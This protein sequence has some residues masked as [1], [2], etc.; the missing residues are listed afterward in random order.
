MLRYCKCIIPS[1]ILILGSNSNSKT[2]NTQECTHTPSVHRN[3]GASKET[4]QFS[5]KRSDKYAKSNNEIESSDTL[6]NN[7]KSLKFIIKLNN[8]NS[9]SDEKTSNSRVKYDSCLSPNLKTTNIVNPKNSRFQRL[10]KRLSK[11]IKKHDASKNET[12]GILEQNCNTKGNI[13]A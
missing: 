11:A 6:L 5:I 2:E 3:N 13:L 4:Q 10:N 9:L 8:C 1:S 7:S 12:D